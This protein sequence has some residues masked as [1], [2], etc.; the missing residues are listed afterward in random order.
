MDGERMLALLQAYHAVRPLNAAE[1][2]AW[3]Q[4]LRRAALRFWLSR[5]HDLHFPQAGELTHAKDPQQ[6]RSVLTMRIAH[7]VNIP[8]ALA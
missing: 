3:P 1:R 2:E 5:L 7:P 4:L 6:F 8:P